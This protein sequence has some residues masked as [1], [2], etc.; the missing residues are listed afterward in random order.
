MA[1]A[2]ADV[3]DYDKVK[4]AILKRY[5]VTEESYR[6]RFRAA[7]LKPGESAKELAVR[8]EDLL[9]KWLKKCKTVEEVK[10]TSLSWRDL[11]RGSTGI[12]QRRKT[13]DM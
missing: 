10:E 11:T 12:R 6:R 9:S 2:T 1:M 7:K 4:A 3:D 5:N 13:R 8:L